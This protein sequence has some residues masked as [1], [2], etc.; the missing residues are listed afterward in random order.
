MVQLN[1]IFSI[2]L[3][4]DMLIHT[5]IKC[6]MLSE[7]KFVFYRPYI[8]TDYLNNLLPHI[9]SVTATMSE[10]QSLILAHTATAL[11]YEPSES[12]PHL[13]RL[14]NTT[15]SQLHRGE[16]QHTCTHACMHAPK[17]Q[18]AAKSCCQHLLLSGF[19][20]T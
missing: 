8:Y 1:L 7:N 9:L 10:K 4:L 5:S 11:Y 14:T 3:F 19:I 6:N 16:L 18:P 17:S 12:T 15:G 20:Y 13:T 2:I